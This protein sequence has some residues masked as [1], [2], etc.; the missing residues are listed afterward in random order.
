MTEYW[1]LQKNDQNFTSSIHISKV[2][3]AKLTHY[4]I[5]TWNVSSIRM[6]DSCEK[7]GVGFALQK[8]PTSILLEKVSVPL[9]HYSDKYL[10]V[11]L[12]NNFE[13]NN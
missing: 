5:Y 11:T 7:M 12:T 13:T 1:W 3:L 9:Q 8:L 6:S 4:V 2:L 10:K